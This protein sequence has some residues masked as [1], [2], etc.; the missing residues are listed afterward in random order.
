MKLMIRLFPILAVV[1][2]VSLYATN[3]KDTP[4]PGLKV[5]AQ[6]DDCGDNELRM[7]ALDAVLQMD[8]DRAMPILLNVLERHD[9]CSEELRRKAVFLVSQQNTSDAEKIL[10]RAVREDPA[11]EVRKQAVFWLSQTG[12]GEAVSV[13]ETVLEESD[14]VELQEQAIFALSQHSGARAEQVL[15]DYV[16]RNDAPLELRENAVFWLGNEGSHESRA[17]LRDLY[18]SM[19]AQQL[20]QKIIFSVAQ[21]SSAESRDWL[22]SVVQN[23]SEPV[24]LRKNALFW[25]GQQHDLEAADLANVYDSSVDLELRQQVL[26]VLSQLTDDWAVDQLIAIAR[27][28]TDAE[29]RKNALFWLGQSD[30]LRAAQFLQEVVAK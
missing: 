27:R 2:A 8:A 17:F 30:D 23:E 26:F 25:T 13:L 21:I 22:L 3:R 6:R 1:A 16:V 20:K 10:L 9:Q 12:G 14:E 29:L 24:E 18:S 7:A 28:E 19:S 5:V 4:I 15:R 11:L